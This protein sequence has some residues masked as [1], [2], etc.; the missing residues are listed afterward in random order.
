[1][2]EDFASSGKG[3]GIIGILLG[4]L[5]LAG[6]TGLG[7]GV[8]S[9]MGT[10]NGDGVD[11]EEA[12]AAGELSRKAQETKI[13]ELN[14]KLESFKA[15]RSRLPEISSNQAEL[16][17]L[18]NVAT[19]MTAEIS[20]LKEAIESEEV[21]FATY[22][23]QYRNNERKRAVGETVDFSDTHG[24][25]FKNVPIK[26]VD[27]QFLQVMTSTGPKGIPF[28]ELPTDVQDRFQ[29]SKDEAEAL[30]KIKAGFQKKQAKRQAEFDKEMA[31]KN[32][33]RKAQKRV[34]RIKQLQG[35]MQQK[36]GVVD[37]N[38]RLAKDSLAKAKQYQ[39][40]HNDARRA[41]KM[42][43]KQGR[44]T[45]ERGNAK[46]YENRA[47]EAAKE[48]ANLQAELNRLTNQVQ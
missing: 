21:A 18:N 17:V 30:A 16:T 44:A 3:P 38:L 14:D 13:T 9:G 28:A 6:F 20:S 42:S 23:Q 39:K 40:E 7:I 19:D 4:T 15:F 32:K 43:M 5:V 26:K 29:F 27:A 24:E 2:F 35:E 25:L 8:Y 48:L 47:A 34:E 37:K 33:Q 46:T 1:M 12:L 31:L 10:G 41:G 11:I 36:Q 45:S 22:R